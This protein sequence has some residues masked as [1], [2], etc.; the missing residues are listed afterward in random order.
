MLVESNKYRQSGRNTYKTSV[1]KFLLGGRYV[2]ALKGYNKIVNGMDDPS[3]LAFVFGIVPEPSGLFATKESDG[4][5]YYDF[6][7][8][9]QYGALNYL[10]SCVKG[11][12]S[13]D[14][15]GMTD[16]DVKLSKNAFTE[17]YNNVTAT[18]MLFP[19]EYANLYSFV[20]GFWEICKAHQYTFQTVEGLQDA[21]KKYYTNKKDSFLGA[22]D[23]KIKITCL[24]SMD[25]RMT[26]LFDA[27][28]NAVFSHKYRR[29][30]IPHNLIRF[31]CYILLHDLRNI[32]PP[33]LTT[34]E[35]MNAAANSDVV[36]NMSTV[37]FVFK[38][39]TIDI[40]EC[41][42]SFST[43]VNNEVN[44][45]KFDFTFNYADLQISVASLADFLEYDAE[46]AHRAYY[47]TLDISAL[48]GVGKSESDADYDN[49]IDNAGA[50]FT[51]SEDEVFGNAYEDTLNIGG[52]LKKA[53]AM[54]FNYLTSGTQMG[55]VYDESWAGMVANMV[56]SISNGGLHALASPYISRGKE[57]VMEKIDDYARE[58]FGN[59]NG[60][61]TK[62]L[63]NTDLNPTTRGERPP[64]PAN[65]GSLGN[66]ELNER[67]DDSST[68]TLGGV[69]LNAGGTQTPAKNLGG[70]EL[71]EKK[72]NSSTK[73]LGGVELNAGGNQAP[74]KTLGGLE[75]N[76]GAPQQP[77]KTLG[78]LEQNP[79][80]SPSGP[81]K[82][83]GK[84]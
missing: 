63:G 3:H 60:G 23:N 84:L 70:V 56:S 25:L 26:A 79:K 6:E 52:F 53:G 1:S 81:V 28:Y 44:E 54:V 22:T 72:S 58:R 30:N 64:Q 4:Y 24:E 68:K 15:G 13:M 37:L 73:T 82:T 9:R 77:T 5:N 31:N 50:E 32:I 69:E 42:Q 38:D 27:Y 11:D 49:Y 59:N 78:G 55:N 29:M 43:T 41:G 47:D 45:T 83:L 36:A 39:C 19:E 66:V 40:D 71:V 7:T 17:K 67:K 2:S 10:E 46:N 65:S 61:E 75:L 48:N 14:G 18:N 57:Y 76:Q 20:Y 12:S 8:D 62:V 35:K 51:Y 34:E 16:E 74:T 21:Y 80:N 33:G